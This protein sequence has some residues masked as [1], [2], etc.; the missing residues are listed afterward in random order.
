[1]SLTTISKIKTEQYTARR[2]VVDEINE[3]IKLLRFNFHHWDMDKID[4]F[5][6][7]GIIYVLFYYCSVT[8]RRGNVISFHRLQAL[9]IV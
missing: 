5:I 8:S 1:M 7:E 6:V 2:I 4:L 9:A 3:L